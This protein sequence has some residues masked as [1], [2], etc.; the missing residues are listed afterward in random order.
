[1]R[2]C[3]PVVLLLA[4]GACEA[5]AQVSAEAG[6]I[7]GPEEA[8]GPTDH[9]PHGARR[10]PGAR[11]KVS[12]VSVAEQPDGEPILVIDYAWKV[13]ARPSIEVCTLPD[14]QSEW[15][16]IRPLFFLDKFFIKE[17]IMKAVY[18]CLDGSEEVPTTGTFAEQDIDFEILG[19]SNSLKKPSVCVACRTK[20]PEIAKGVARALFCLLDP[21]A[22][23]E[24]TLYLDLPQKHFAESGQIRVWFL[25]R[26]AVLWSETVAWP[27]FSQ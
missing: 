18:R 22:V 10:S 12:Y 16:A 9:A 11:L 4:I 20:V 15:P 25:R 5:A 6:H 2:A 24:R 1:M 3:L 14:D 7:Q 13:H 21:W 19:D 26:Q 23:D 17:R 8:A 27:G